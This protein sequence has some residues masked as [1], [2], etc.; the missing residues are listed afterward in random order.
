MSLC[1]RT[2]F[3]RL[4][5][6]SVW[7][8]RLSLQTVW[9]L[10]LRSTD[11]R[12]KAFLSH[13]AQRISESSSESLVTQRSFCW[14]FQRV[15]LITVIFAGHFTQSFKSVMLVIKN[16]ILTQILSLS[17]W[18]YYYSWLWILLSAIA[19]QTC[20]SALTVPLIENPLSKRSLPLRCFKGENIIITFII[21][22]LWQFFQ[23]G[24]I[25]SHA[26]VLQCLYN[27]LT[28]CE[29]PQYYPRWVG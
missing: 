20:Y 13:S 9:F 1:P 17:Q 10:R 15:I 27:A 3:L 6:Q 2:V 21:S 28:L 12:T 4:C 26:N 24:K 5:L 18:E 7:I 19:M 16:C 25:S 29:W 8:W 22:Y 14:S 23:N 11:I